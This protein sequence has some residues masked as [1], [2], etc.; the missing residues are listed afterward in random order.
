MVVKLDDDGSV[1]WSKRI[2][3]DNFKSSGFSVVYDDKNAYIF[4]T[5]EPDYGKASNGGMF[6]M[7]VDI[8]GEMNSI[9]EVNTGDEVVSTEIYTVD[10]R[11]V[12]RMENG[13][14]IVRTTY[15]NG[16]VTTTKVVR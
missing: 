7:C 11:R 4:Y 5:Q 12:S 13:V 9:N 8:V 1:L 16:V 14:N 15:K 3:E 10:G 2:C 6:V